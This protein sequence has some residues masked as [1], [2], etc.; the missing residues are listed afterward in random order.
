MLFVYNTKK[1]SK[2]IIFDTSLYSQ[3]FQKDEWN[4]I[5][6][7]NMMQQLEQNTGSSQW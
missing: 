6:K 4:S 2:K 1:K 5:G 7:R 3:Q